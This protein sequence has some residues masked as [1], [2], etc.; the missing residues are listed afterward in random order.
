MNT[1]KN[2]PR[3]THLSWGKMEVS[4]LGCGKD[5][6]LWPGGGENWDWRTTGTQH[7]PGILPADIQELIDKGSEVL[8]LSRGMLKMLHTSQQ[9][10]EL[11]ESNQ[12]EFY[13]EPT[14][15]AVERYNQLSSEGKMVGGLFHSTC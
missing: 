13:I 9:A 3:I 14:E 1:P 11:M 7:Q 15:A 12:I 5:F 6:K 4:G 2:S 8:V 10:L